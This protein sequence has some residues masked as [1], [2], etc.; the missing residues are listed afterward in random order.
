V[1]DSHRGP[2]LAGKLRLF[3]R[4]LISYND[5]KHAARVAEHI[6]SENLH[7]RSG[8]TESPAILEALNCA[9]K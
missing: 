4:L 6:L 8:D 7:A 1:S 5:F 9:M 2:E 3:Y